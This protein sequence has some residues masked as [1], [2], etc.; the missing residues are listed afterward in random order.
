[1]KNLKFTVSLFFLMCI[2]F[3]AE[4]QKADSVSPKTSWVSKISMPKFSMPKINVPKVSMPKVHMPNFSLFSPKSKVAKDSTPVKPIT[5]LDTT[6]AKPKTSW[7]SKIKFPTIHLPKK[8]VDSVKLKAENDSTKHSAEVK[9]SNKP[10]VKS[11]IEI[12]TTVKA[13][14]H[15]S[16][17]FSKEISN[18]INKFSKAHTISLLVG[19]N[20]SKQTI[21]S[22]GYA[23]DFNYN[24]Q[25]INNDVYKTGFFGG[26]R[27]DGKYHNKHEYSLSVALSKIN[28]GAKYTE[29]LKLTPVIGSFTSFKAEDQFV[30]MN[31]A[32]HYKKQIQIGDPTKYKF[33]IVAGPSIDARVSGTSLEN[34][35]TAA[36]KRLFLKGDIGFEFNNRSMYTLFLQYQHNIGSLTKFPVNTNLSSFEFGV[37][38]KAADLF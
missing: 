25:D 23:S 38:V 7:S 3:T 11:I 24:L 9:A 27:F 14:A 33:Y 22:G 6:I 20:F 19:A 28:A 30:V 4:A 36:Y 13:N 10:K 15:R 2:V 35:V 32:A 1:M 26:V 8:Q 21:A 5:Q 16:K 31:I 34:D 18:S 17:F 12:D 29:P 37:V